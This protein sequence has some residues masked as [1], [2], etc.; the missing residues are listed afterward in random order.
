MHF[1]PLN[2]KYNGF[3]DTRKCPDSLPQA[4]SSQIHTQ[5]RSVVTTSDFFQ[6]ENL[7][8]SLLKKVALISFKRQYNPNLKHE[9]NRASPKTLGGQ[10]KDKLKGNKR[11]GVLQL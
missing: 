10:R 1:H 3:I 2:G 4:K 11:K 7:F 5:Q 8:Y 6:G 9:Q